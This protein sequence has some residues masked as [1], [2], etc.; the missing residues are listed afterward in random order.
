MNLCH[1][2][3]EIVIVTFEKSDFIVT[4]N[5]TFFSKIY[6][7]VMQIFYCKLK[8]DLLYSA[9]EFDNIWLSDMRRLSVLEQTRP[10][11]SEHMKR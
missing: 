10:A 2:H 5:F 6:V 1:S 7:V 8:P 11:E 4:V 9:C 3:V